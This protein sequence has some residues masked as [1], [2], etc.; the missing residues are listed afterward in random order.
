MSTVIK[1]NGLSKAYQLGQFST[2]TIT[3]DIRRWWALKRG[4]EDPYLKIGEVNDRTKA[5]SNKIVWS[6]KD[7]GF[8]IKGG[9]SVG[10]IGRNGAGKSTLLKLL[11][12]I[13][14]PTS[15]NIKILGRVASLLEVGTGFHPELTGKENVF[16]NGAILGMSKDEIKRKFDEIVDF[17]GVERYLDTPVKRYSSGMYVRLAFAVAAHL[18]SEILIVDEVLAVGDVEFQKKCLGKMNDITKGEG[19]TILFVSHNLPMIASLCNKG[20]VL[21]QGRLVFDGLS[22]TAINYYQNGENLTPGKVSYPDEKTRPGDSL[23]GLVEAFLLNSHGEISAELN[24]VEAFTVK[25]VYEI[26]QAG[27]KNAYPNFHFLDQFGQYVFVTSPL[28]GMIDANNAVG[29]Y[30]AQCT[31]PANFLNAGNFS[32][33][34]AFTCDFNGAHTSFYEQNAINFSMIEDLN[35]SPTRIGNYGGALPGTVR[36]IL[37]WGIEKKG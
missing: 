7:I 19:R 16:L 21:D 9:D 36:P 20:L 15:G 27:L 26:K 35:N 30:E 29:Q 31:I 13:T 18:E 4:K 37:N 28:K 3:D 6:L 11:S 25:I 22:S 10:V 2:G 24:I 5:S 23:A 17:S 33:S 32:I 14:S 1:V 34:V 8:E 12:Q